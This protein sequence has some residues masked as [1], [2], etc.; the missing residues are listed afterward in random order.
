MVTNMTFAEILIFA[1][2]LFAAFC[3][4]TWFGLTL[5]DRVDDER[6]DAP[7]AP[8]KTDAEIAEEEA[9][10]IEEREKQWQNMMLYSGKNQTE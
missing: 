6:K 8:P 7:A 1:L 9:R 10:L 3:G 5:A 4:G 2:L